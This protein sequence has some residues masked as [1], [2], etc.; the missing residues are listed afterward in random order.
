M[1]NRPALCRNRLRD[2]GKHYPRSGCKSCGN[3]GMMGC[4]YEKGGLPNNIKID[5]PEPVAQ[6]VATAAAI[7]DLQ[8]A[9]Y[10]MR[11]AVAAIF[12]E[13]GMNPELW[14]DN[15]LIAQREL[16]AAQHKMDF[17]E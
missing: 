12:A 11:K 14:F 10:K 6:P 5:A 8:N 15:L 9:A 2:E 4:P 17:K 13:G 3:G 7:A 1:D 16:A